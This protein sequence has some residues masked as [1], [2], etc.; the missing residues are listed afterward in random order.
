MA[1]L[2]YT[3]RDH[4][5]EYERLIALVKSLCPNWTDWNYSD[6]GSA[7]IAAQSSTTDGLNKNIDLAANENFV[8]T[9]LFRQTLI[10]LGKSVGYLPTLMSAASTKLR[11]TRKPGVTDAVTVPKWTPWGRSDGLEYLTIVDAVIPV[12]VNTIDIDALQGVLVEKI[13]NAADFAV[14]DMSGHP[15]YNLGSNVA[16]GTLEMTHGDPAVTWTEPE[17]CFAFSSATDRHFVLE[18]NGN[19]DT[20]WLTLGNGIR[21]TGPAD[22]PMSVKFIRTAGA[23]GNAGSGVVTIV[24]D[25]LSA[26]ITCANT[27]IATGGAASE[28]TESI[29][30]MIP[31]WARL[32]RNAVTVADYET[33]LEHLAG[34]LHVKA[35]DRQLSTAWPHEHVVLFI[36]PDGGGEMSSYLRT[37]VLDLCGRRGIYGRW[38]GRYVINNA[39]AKLV[40]MA[41]RIGVSDGYVPATVGAAAGAALEAL[42]APE[43]QPIEGRLR[44]ADLHAAASA[45]PGLSWIEF[46]SPKTDILAGVGEQLV[47][48]GVVV[49]VQ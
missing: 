4:T 9:A 33:L 7:I 34:L 47:S 30:N 15:R 11:F 43:L 24:P 16:S 35:Y 22:T 48:G 8:N 31:R 38:S 26:L 19:D 44:F 23:E 21:G 49:T 37:S 32:G 6:F 41:V 42:L 1:L 17:E 46:D 29:R 14:T 5:A 13:L 45:L 25:S 20:V 40:T 18:L 2:N 12:G 27:D 10:N 28:S 36:A 3:G 39:V